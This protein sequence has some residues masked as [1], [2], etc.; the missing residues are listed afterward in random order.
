LVALVVSN[1]LAPQKA[2]TTKVNTPR[3]TAPTNPK[4]PKLTDALQQCWLFMP[5]IK[6]AGSNKLLNKVANKVV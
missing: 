3:K 4:A 1:H 5:V 6:L 2:R